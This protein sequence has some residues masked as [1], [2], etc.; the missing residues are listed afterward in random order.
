MFLCS[1]TKYLLLQVEMVHG[2]RLNVQKFSIGGTPRKVLYHSESRTLLVMR[3]GLNGTSYS[4]DI[5][6]VDPLSGSLLSKFRFEPGETA[7]CMEIM[8]VGNEHLLIVGTMQS[9]GRA[10][11]PSGEAERLFPIPSPIHFSCPFSSQL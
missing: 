4:S 9:S 10:I 2:K 7:K 11:M 5:C 6:R 1:I 3:T 8:R